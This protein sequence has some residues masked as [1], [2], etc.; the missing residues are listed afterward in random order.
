MA[1]VARYGLPHEEA[2]VDACHLCY[3]AREGLR[4]RFPEFLAPDEMY[5]KLA[6]G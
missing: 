3:L 5:G 6:E 4:S 1:L 2:Y